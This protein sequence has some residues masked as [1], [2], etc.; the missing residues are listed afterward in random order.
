MVVSVII[1]ELL[2]I[3]QISVSPGADIRSSPGTAQ[4]N[5]NG[6][7]VTPNTQGSGV[8]HNCQVQRKRFHSRPDIPKP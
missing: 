2:A 6:V 8:Q 5:K 4:R 1:H 3:S 7:V